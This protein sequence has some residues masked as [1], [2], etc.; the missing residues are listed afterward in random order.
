MF[1]IADKGVDRL[2]DVVISQQAHIKELEHELFR[3]NLQIEQMELTRF[4]TMLRASKTKPSKESLAE[5]TNVQG[6][7]FS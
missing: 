7:H 6:H 1:G 3:A 4:A 2:L 5:S